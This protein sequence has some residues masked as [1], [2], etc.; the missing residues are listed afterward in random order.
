MVAF[1]ELYQGQLVV[2]NIE[3]FPD[4][5]GF[6]SVL[7]TPGPWAGGFDLPFG[8]PRELINHFGWSTCWSEYIRTYSSIA[9]A[10]LRDS[11]KSFCDA[12][13]AG[14]KFAHRETDRPAGSSPSMKWVNPPVA[15]MLHAGAPRLLDAGVT[16]PGMLKG[17]PTRIALE[18]YPGMPARSVSRASY[19]SDNP[20]RQTEERRVVRSQIIKAMQRG[21]TQPGVITRMSGSLR[22]RLLDDASGDA[23]DSVLCLVQ[24]AWAL[25]HPKGRFGLPTRFDRTEGWIV[26][27]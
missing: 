6:E 7:Q 15:W 14:A 8:L 2:N 25:N 24:V 22:R 11:F 23:L 3:S 12:R 20:A 27:A 26:G 4:F 16:I 19:K 10:E 21:E 5:A 9:R 13:P 18:A 1:G 17:D